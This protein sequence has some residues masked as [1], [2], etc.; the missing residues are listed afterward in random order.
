MNFDNFTQQVALQE[1]S[2]ELLLASCLGLLL[3]GIHSLYNNQWLRQKNTLI[4]ALVLPSVS[5]VIT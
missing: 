5:L 3:I 2:V 4:M 1:T